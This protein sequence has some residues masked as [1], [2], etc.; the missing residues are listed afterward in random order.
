[1]TEKKWATLHIS[2][3]LQQ[4]I[5]LLRSEYV[6]KTKQVIKKS[7][8]LE[9]IIEIAEEHIKK[10]PVTEIADGKIVTKKADEEQ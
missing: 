6:V 7:D 1:M 8:F 4:K 10:L 9:L 5:F 3:K 2:T